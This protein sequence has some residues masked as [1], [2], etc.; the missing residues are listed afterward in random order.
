MAASWQFRGELL[1]VIEDGVT[2]NDELERA[3]VRE[4]LADPRANPGL[5]VLWDS[6]L[7]VTPIAA[8]DVEWRS[9]MLWELAEHNRVARLALL[10]APRQGLTAA[11]LRQ[12]RTAIPGLQ[13]EVFS[14]ETEAVAWLTSR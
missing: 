2:S 5:A 13:L 14:D 9:R 10:L 3:F 12:R 8:E 7:S 6:R 1:V 11:T 4:A